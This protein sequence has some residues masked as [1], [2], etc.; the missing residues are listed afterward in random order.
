MWWRHHSRR[1][2]N[3][4]HICPWQTSLFCT[5]IKYMNPIFFSPAG[6]KAT[7]WNVCFYFIYF[8]WERLKHLPV[9]LCSNSEPLLP[10][11]K[12]KTPFRDTHVPHVISSLALE[13]VKGNTWSKAKMQLEP[14]T[15]PVFFACVKPT[16]YGIITV[17]IYSTYIHTVLIYEKTCMKLLWHA[18]FYYICISLFVQCVC[19]VHN[20]TFCMYVCFCF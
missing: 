11:S 12:N 15:E 6:R 3:L 18:C 20:H 19:D 13:R 4:T 10:S 2:G 1:S 16:V 7:G 17:C 8:H 9:L 5:N 14:S